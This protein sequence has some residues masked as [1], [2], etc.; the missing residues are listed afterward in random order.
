MKKITAV[1]GDTSSKRSRLV[2]ARGTSS[3]SSEFFFLFPNFAKTEIHDL[4][5]PAL[6]VYGIAIDEKGKGTKKRLN[7]STR[8]SKAITAL[9]TIRPKLKG[10][11]G[12]GG[13]KIAETSLDGKQLPR[14]ERQR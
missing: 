12:G 4:L 11:G 9:L 3:S 1:Y 7:Q 14:I 2:N 8:A 10:G 6:Y 13:G 5:R